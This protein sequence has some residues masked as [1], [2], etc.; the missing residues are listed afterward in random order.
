VVAAALLPRFA[1]VPIELLNLLNIDCEITCGA[2]RP[3]MKRRLGSR[4]ELKYAS[5]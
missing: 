3:G 1:A 2:I 5:K 4:K